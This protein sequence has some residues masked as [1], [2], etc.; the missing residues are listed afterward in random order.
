M[1][2]MQIQEA[3]K[4]KDKKKKK[5]DKKPDYDD[6][7][8]VL[9]GPVSPLSL[10]KD[11][12]APADCGCMAPEEP[13]GMVKTIDIPEDIPSETPK[14]P[15]EIAILICPECSDE[16][17]FS[18]APPPGIPMGRRNFHC[19]R[20]GSSVNFSSIGKDASSGKFRVI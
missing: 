19:R 5:E 2:I 20:C 12:D 15:E 13:A 7:P 9:E 4:K 3:A 6:V 18:L 16:A 1:S 17:P 14:G 10:R 11:Y 8:Q